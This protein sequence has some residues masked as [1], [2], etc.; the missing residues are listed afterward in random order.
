MYWAVLL[1]VV[2]NPIHAQLCIRNLLKT[3]KSPV[4]EVTKV[5]ALT[6]SE[7]GGMPV[8]EQWGPARHTQSRT[9]D[10]MP[11][12]GARWSYSNTGKLASCVLRPGQLDLLQP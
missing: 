9:L 8:D 5:R 11:V 1:V 2:L 4:F 6:A 12:S 10:R 7:R 3:W